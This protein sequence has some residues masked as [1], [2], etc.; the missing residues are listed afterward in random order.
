MSG[1]M[2]WIA[3]MFAPRQ[4]PPESTLRLEVTMLSNAVGELLEGLT[5]VKGTLE[6]FVT[7]HEDLMAKTDNLRS[8]LDRLAAA[9]DLMSNDIEALTTKVCTIERKVYNLHNNVSIKSVDS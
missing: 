3:E 7:I 5:H 6:K 4:P 2:G 8:D 1:D 9:C